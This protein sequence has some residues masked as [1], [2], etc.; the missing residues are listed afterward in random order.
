MLNILNNN[1]FVKE[2]KKYSYDKNLRTTIIEIIK[3]INYQIIIKNRYKIIINNY[4]KNISNI[5]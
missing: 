3:N 1:V 2:A 5:K 4:Y